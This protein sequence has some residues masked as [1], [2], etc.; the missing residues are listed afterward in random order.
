MKPPW[1]EMRQDMEIYTTKMMLSH[2]TEC[3]FC[4]APG[5]SQ[6][7]QQV[8]WKMRSHPVSQNCVVKHQNLQ[9]LH[10][11]LFLLAIFVYGKHRP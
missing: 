9:D 4:S 11:V 10:Q 8:L 2:T 6:K 3:K 1:D 7:L 5:S